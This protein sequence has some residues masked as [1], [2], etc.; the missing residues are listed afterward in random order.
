MKA[1]Y[2]IKKKDGVLWIKMYTACVYPW[3]AASRPIT[4]RKEARS[5]FAEFVREIR[6]EQQ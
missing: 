2:R 1:F 3:F 4:N 6:L 5:A